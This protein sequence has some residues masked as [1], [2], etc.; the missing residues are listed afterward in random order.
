MMKKLFIA[1]LNLFPTG[2][3]F[4]WIGDINL[5]MEG[6]SLFFERPLAYVRQAINESQPLKADDTLETWYKAI[7]L[8]YDSNASIL[9]R[10]RRISQ[11]VNSIGAQNIVYLR[12]K[13]NLA[14][15]QIQ[16]DEYNIPLQS[17]VGVAQV[18]LA[19]VTNFPS[20]IPLEFYD[21]PDV[22]SLFKVSGSVDT[23]RQFVQLQDIIARYFPLRLQPVYV[24]IT[25]LQQAGVCAIGQVGIAEVGRTVENT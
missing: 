5:L 1:F 22:G 17:Q 15:P 3:I 11:V 19:Q 24:D 12:D 20:W 2:L 25:F 16:I 8:V 4:K 13:V 21:S 23:I 9:D 14:F 7:N 6:I 18:G 10:Q